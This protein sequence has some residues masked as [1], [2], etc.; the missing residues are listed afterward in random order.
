MNPFKRAPRPRQKQVVRPVAE[1]L[2]SRK[3]L[4][5]SSGNTFAIVP[6]TIDAPNGNVSVAFT[7]NPSHFTLP[8]G[9]IAMGIDIAADPSGTLKPVIAS[10]T[11]PHGN[12]IPQTFHS[13]YDPLVARRQ[14]QNGRTTSSVLSPLTSLPSDPNE[15]VTYTVQVRAK[16]DTSGKFLVGFYLPGDAN[17]DGKVEKTDL[18]IVRSQNGAR[19]GDQRYT[20]DADVNRDGRIGPI[21]INYTKQNQGVATTITPVLG[22]NLDTTSV[23]N[24]AGRANNQ[25]TARFTGTGTPN[26]VV[27]FVNKSHSTEPPVSTDIDSSGNYTITTSL[28]EGE[29]I[30]EVTSIDAFGQVIKGNIAPVYYTTNNVQLS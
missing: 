17:G 11:D 30:F 25:P 1:A 19:A 24:P 29:N 3:L 23:S 22:A 4:T 7:I 6:G 8:K 9:K 21:D 14:V 15:P 13:T 28:G 27:A 5:G 12:I 20:F 16:N 10:V 2:E 26:A 18:K